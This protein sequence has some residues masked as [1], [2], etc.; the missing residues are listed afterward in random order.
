MVA[1]EV[2]KGVQMIQ[3][4]INTLM[5]A[6]GQ[7]PFS[8]LFIYLNEAPEGQEREDLALVA[9]EI[10]RQRIKGVKNKSGAW[11]A[12]AFPK[13][14]YVIDETNSD[15]TK[16][17]WNL[18]KLAAECTAKRMVP[19][20]ISE[21]IMKEYK[22]GNVYGA[23]GAVHS[24]S[25]VYYKIDGC[26]YNGTIKDMYDHL[27]SRNIIEEDQFGQNG[28]PNKDLNLKNFNVKIFDNSEDKFVKCNMMN[29]NVASNFKLF[30]IKID[31][32]G[33]EKTI[34]AT[35]D[36]PL[37]SPKTSPLYILP[38]QEYDDRADVI[39]VE[40]LKVG[41][42]VYASRYVSENN[43]G[44]LIGCATP[45]KSKV[46]S[47]EEYTDSEEFV[48][49]VTTET[50]HFMVNDIFSHNCRA[51]LSVWH[52]PETGKP[53]FWGRLTKLEVKPSLNCV[54]A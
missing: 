53:K 16:P 19:D 38:H 37:M 14:I 36:H 35:N 41:D 21:K 40:N 3:Y 24:S 15:N 44:S 39:R 10:L 33:V 11:V 22:D 12:P 51:F 32:E 2:K 23:M 29:K 48:Y 26:A 1:E 42:Y 7:T 27:K 50:G 5:T 8:T 6:N 49:D 13:I 34:I 46:V 47:I 17:Y 25:K 30:K 28:N 52:D 54:N 18:T 20:Y 45:I 4:Q 9:S 31:C 43:G